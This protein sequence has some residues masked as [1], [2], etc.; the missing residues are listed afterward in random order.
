VN[1]I[2]EQLNCGILAIPDLSETAI[3]FLQNAAISGQHHSYMP[4]TLLESCPGVAAL[5]KAPSM[6]TIRDFP[7]FVLN[8][9]IRP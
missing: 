7:F 3:H 9:A 1:Q 2:V 4:I 8:K 6:S 5:C